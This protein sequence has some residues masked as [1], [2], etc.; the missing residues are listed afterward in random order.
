M[1]GSNRLIIDEADRSVHDALCVIRSLVKERFLVN[2]GGA[3]EIELSLQLAKFAE[4]TGGMEGY[5]IK[6]YAKALEI[7][8]YTLAEN[9]GLHPINIVTELR[10]AHAEGNKFAGINVRKVHSYTHARK[11]IHPL[12]QTQTQGLHH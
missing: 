10:N 1:R 9:A 2:G 5:C 8:P 12:T 4:E 3:P 7:I 11:F 6:E